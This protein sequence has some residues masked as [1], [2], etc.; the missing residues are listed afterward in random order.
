VHPIVQNLNLHN[1]TNGGSG[2]IFANNNHLGFFNNIKVDGYGC[3]T[4]FTLF[5]G[6]FTSSLNLLEN[7]VVNSSGNPGVGC[8][9][10]EREIAYGDEQGGEG[11]LFKND[12]AT[13]L[14]GNN[15]NK[16]RLIT[17]AFSDRQ[18]GDVY[19]GLTCNSPAGQGFTD[20]ITIG[21]SSP[22]VVKNSQISCYSGCLVGEV[23]GDQFV[24]NTSVG[25][26]NGG[27]LNVYL[28]TA[29]VSVIGNTIIQNAS[30]R[31]YALYV[32]NADPSYGSVIE[33]NILKC[34]ASSGGSCP[35]GLYISSPSGESSSTQPL[36]IVGN[37]VTGFENDFV[38]PG[39]AVF[40][41]ATISDNP[42]LPDQS[43]E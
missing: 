10:G 5:P 6:G 22:T 15:S 18:Q 8:G 1:V 33:N 17:C 32:G 34:Q 42:G 16:A 29:P 35:N 23:A 37:Q 36:T 14:A 13:I 21:G 40:P 38:Y 25:I 31:T 3:T 28:P 2:A 7:S 26:G 41:D 11:N 24:N 4:D 12:T 20:D 43:P 30:G 19:D 27:S 39:A 9:S